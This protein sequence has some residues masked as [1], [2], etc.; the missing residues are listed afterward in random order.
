[1]PEHNTGQMGGTQRLGKRTTVFKSTV[2]NSKISEFS[3]LKI[4]LVVL[5][6]CFLTEKLY[7]NKAQ[8]EERHRHRYEVNPEYVNELEEHGLKFVGT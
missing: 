8:I 1:M 5:N 7:G 3:L 4:F 2:E 6:K